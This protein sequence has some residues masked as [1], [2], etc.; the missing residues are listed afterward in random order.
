VN[1]KFNPLTR[2]CTHLGGDISTGN[3]IM[4]MNECPRHHVHFDITSGACLYGPNIGAFTKMTWGKMRFEM[5]MDG[6]RIKVGL[7]TRSKQESHPLAS[8]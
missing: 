1:G 7:L 2:K 3:L 6:N 8:E 4:N 5:I